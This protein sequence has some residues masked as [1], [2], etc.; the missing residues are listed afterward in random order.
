M[1]EPF[2]GGDYEHHNHAE[3]PSYLLD[4]VVLKTIGVDVGS[5]T[6]HL[7]F[8]TLH[9]R[10]E[11]NRL[12]AK[13]EIVSRKVIWRSGIE[14]TPYQGRLIDA[15]AIGSFVK[16]CYEDADLAPNQID[17]GAVILTGE[18]LRQK[19]ARAIAEQIAMGSGD[20]V[21]VSAGHH[22]EAMLAAQGSGAAD[23]SSA[24]D[25]QLLHVDIGGGT[26]KISFIDGGR[27][28]A[29]A[30]IMVGGRQ[31]AWDHNR[32]IASTT[33][34]A[35]IIARRAGIEIGTG[36]TFSVDDEARFVQ[37]QAQI[38]FDIINKIPN[39][40]EPRLRLTRVIPKKLIPEYV[41][42]SGGVSEYIYGRTSSDYGDLG[43][44]LGSA[45]KQ[46]LENHRASFTL[47]DPGEGIRATVAG[48]SQC[49]LQ[50]SGNTVTVSDPD[51]LPIRNVPVIHPSMA[52]SPVTDLYD[53]AKSQKEIVA[54]MALFQLSKDDAV[55]I[56][57]DW[58]GDPSHERMASLARIIQ[59]SF[60]CDTDQPLVVM[61][62]A[63]IAA[64]IGS[65]LIS[66]FPLNRPLI[67]L[68]G[69]DSSPLDFVDVGSVLEPSGALPV[70]IKSLLFDAVEEH[71]VV[72]Q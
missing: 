19:N 13:Y 42:F 67:C 49:S 57:V 62:N 6:F 40:T 24:N 30:A 3:D 47:I 7:M 21:C 64:S 8:A 53:F 69:L 23:Y 28:S 16:R 39:V 70:V 43:H 55:A 52:P 15:E 44:S 9:L 60:A 56:A 59:S 66:E 20:F 17:T 22:L 12:S 72:A 4:N 48:A 35:R 29:S 51:A 68:D 45:I 32:V 36:S 65:L 37:A 41:S 61:F 46:G 31:I 58:D 18:A 71:L 54:A 10:R 5:S 11:V 33:A 26:T 27:V 34:G 38:I 1:H 2:G 25:V 14:I 63:D 50:L